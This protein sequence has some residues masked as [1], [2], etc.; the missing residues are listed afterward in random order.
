MSHEI[1]YGVSNSATCTCGE[2]FHGAMAVDLDEAIEAHL[3]KVVAQ[4]T[5][6]TPPWDAPEFT[7][8]NGVPWDKAP[9]PARRHEHFVQTNLWI[10]F[11]QKQW[12]ACGASRKNGAHPRWVESR[13]PKVTMTPTWWDR[14]KARW[15]R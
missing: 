11:S 13:H 8:L 4:R 5:V 14:L 15:S 10:G 3:L 9:A 12:C 7:H 2:K 6:N 1:T